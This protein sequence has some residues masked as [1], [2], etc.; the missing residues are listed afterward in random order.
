[1]IH[2]GIFLGHE[3]YKITS[4]SGKYIYLNIVVPQKRA[5]KMVSKSGEDMFFKEKVALLI[6]PCTSDIVQL[7]FTRLCSSLKILTGFYRKYN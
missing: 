6:Y 3:V 4:I 5:L 1:M 7:E 2:N